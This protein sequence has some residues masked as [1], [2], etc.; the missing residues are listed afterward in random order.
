MTKQKFK[1]TNLIL[2]LIKLACILTVFIL[3]LT[4]FT[5]THTV[6]TTGYLLGEQY[7]LDDEITCSDAN[8]FDLSNYNASFDNQKLYMIFVIASLA[9]LV[10]IGLLDLLVFSKKARRAGGISFLMFAST[11]IPLT[12]LVFAFI[13]H[14]E[15]V[16][17]VLD[18]S[19]EYIT[20]YGYSGKLVTETSL[21]LD[22]NLIFP[23]ILLF[24]VIGLHIVS[25]VLGCS[26]KEEPV[27]EGEQDI[28][29]DGT[30]SNEDA[31]VQT[32]EDAPVQASDDSNAEQ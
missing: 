29:A 20:V 12:A 28:T 9:V 3:L 16:R 30:E 31:S 21:T 32:E 7:E 10:T 5:I 15:K 6:K 24:A 26:V 8:F 17:Y 19:T 25:C 11:A 18:V 23:I 14:L 1:K 27:L 2:T 22:I 13:T 4:P